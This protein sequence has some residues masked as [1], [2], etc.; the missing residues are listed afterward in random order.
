MKSP[1]TW[2][3]AAL[4]VAVVSWFLKPAPVATLSFI[5]ICMGLIMVT[6]MLQYA[7]DVQWMWGYDGLLANTLL[8]Y[9][10]HP[11]RH[12]TVLVF[13]LLTISSLCFTVGFATRVTGI[14]AAVCQG[15]IGSSSYMHSWGWSTVMPVILAIVALSPARN[16]WSVDAWL[17][18]RRGRP[19]PSVAPR[20]ALRLLQ[21]HVMGIYIA[22]SWHRFDDPGWIN[23]EMVY[24]AV[25]NSMYS[26]LPY[27]DPHPY[28]GLFVVLTY[29]TE[30]IEV[31]APFFLWVRKVRVP[32][33]V[34]LIL[35]HLGLELSATIG[36]WQFMMMSLLWVFLPAAWAE[37]ALHRLPKHASA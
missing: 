18:A 22:A 31:V 14:T 35:V 26:R 11:L 8:D 2:H 12:H 9:A 20:W 21:V 28:K 23:G 25:A 37:R 13:T 33:V 30:L 6:C 34:G 10:D 19:L 7:P 36:Y 24:A 17:A 27:F 1:S 4:E 32:V 3:P 15:I 16:A 29:A 5:R